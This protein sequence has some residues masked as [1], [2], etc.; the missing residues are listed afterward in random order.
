MSKFLTSNFFI[1]LVIIA[2]LILCAWQ[3]F[4]IVY[5]I[6]SSIQTLNNTSQR[7]LQNIQQQV[8]NNDVKPSYEYLKSITV[9]IK[10]CTSELPI[11]EAEKF[12]QPIAKEAMCWA[13]T[14]VVIKT[15]K[16]STY[17][18]T[19]GHVAGREMI[20]P[21]LFVL[22]EEREVRAELIAMHSILDLAVIKI[23]GQLKDKQAVNGYANAGIQD[24]VYIVG[25]PLANKYI[26]TEGVVAGYVGIDMLIQA[27]C[28][29]GNS[30]SGVINNRGEL[31]ALVYA[32]QGYRGFLGLPM[33][34]ITHALTIDSLSIQQFIKKL[35][36][37][38]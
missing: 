36:L 27:P 7:A 9:Y 20:D 18:L 24:T 15:T 17:I 23:P 31:V 29:Y 1:K 14:G 5:L 6:Q 30:G 13:G 12:I 26:Y 11:D 25:H 22:N 33:A 8:I 21:I 4:T 2:L 28:I 32:L 34:Q 3:G 35:N 10:G 19:N 38:D 37:M 16:N